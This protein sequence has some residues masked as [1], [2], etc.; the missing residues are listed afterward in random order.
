MTITRSLGSLIVAGVL[1]ATSVA[2]ADHAGVIVTGEATLQ[3]QLN[4]QVQSWL[5][6]HG[7]ELVAAPLDPEATSTLIDCFVIGDDTCARNL[8]EQ[9]GR[10]DTVVFARVDSTPNPESD[11]TRD[12]QVLAYWLQKGHAPIAE[13]RL[14]ERCTDKLMR[15]ATEDVMAALVALRTTHDPSLTVAD[16]QTAAAISEPA[17]ANAAVSAPVDDDRGRARKVLPYALLGG[18]AALAITGGVLIAANQSPDPHGVQQPTYR[19][20]TTPGVVLLVIGAGAAAAG[21][22]LWWHDSKHGAPIAAASHD[23]AVIGWAGRF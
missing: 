8:V 19:D 23:S 20:T 10:A 6:H 11:G 9:H 21:G 7:H 17:S 3:P 15:A 1:A 18:G 4:A 5:A 2:R 14:C 22:Y 13:R 12:V 16:A